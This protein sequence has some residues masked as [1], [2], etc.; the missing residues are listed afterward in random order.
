MFEYFDIEN[1]DN[2]NIVDIWKEYDISEF[3]TD[4]YTIYIPS[5]Y[6]NLQLIS[7]NFYDTIDDWWVIYLFNELY[8]V[9]FHMYNDDI[10]QS[11]LDNHSYYIENY[12]TIS[13][14]YKNYIKEQ[15]R[16]YFMES[17][18]I[19]EAIVLTEEFLNNQNQDDIDTF[20][21]YIQDKI[22]AD[23]I[24]RKGIKIPNTLTAYKIKNYFESLSVKWN[25]K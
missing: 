21:I 25:N 3:I 16:N 9:N 22:V 13:I 12:D 7:Y 4:D 18:T 6:E 5:E 17:Y 20:L 10:L 2:I 19:K 1:I 8:D 14:K 24:L 23:S 11:T 15:L